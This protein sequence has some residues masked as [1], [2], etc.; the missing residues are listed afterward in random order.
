METGV[1][2]VVILDQTLETSY[3]F[4]IF[5]D[6]INSFQKCTSLEF[7][8]FSW[9]SEARNVK[10]KHSSDDFAEFNELEKVKT[11]PRS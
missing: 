10:A 7:I 8:K 11:Q 5:F 2:S 9:N 4:I 6:F 3:D 1:C